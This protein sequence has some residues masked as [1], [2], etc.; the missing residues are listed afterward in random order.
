MTTSDGASVAVR[1]AHG[2]ALDARSRTCRQVAVNYIHSNPVDIDHEHA[3]ALLP[4]A[5]SAS[6]S[7]VR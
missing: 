2:A 1:N 3:P 6:D 4:N 5:T 7:S